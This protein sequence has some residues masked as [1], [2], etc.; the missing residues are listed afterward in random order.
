[1][2]TAIL[3]PQNLVK[4]CYAPCP[5]IDLTLRS[6]G[7]ER[8]QVMNAQGNFSFAG[9]G[10]SPS[11]TPTLATSGAGAA[12]PTGKYWAYR[13]VWVAKTKFPK[14]ENAVTGNGSPAPRTNP[15]PGSATSTGSLTANR[16]VTVGCSSDPAISHIWIYRTTYADS[17]VE[18][19]TFSDAGVLFWIGEVAND[20]MSATTT[21][22][23][24]SAGAGLEQIEND[25]FDAPQ[26][27]LC[28]FADPYFYGIGNND[29]VCNVSIGTDNVVM[30]VPARS[31][32]EQWF[33]GRDGQTIT[34]QD[35]S[36]GGYD[37]FGSFYFKVISG[38]T[39]ELYEDIALTTIALAGFTG[40]TQAT[41]RGNSHT[42]YRSKP[43]NPLSWGITDVIDDLLVPRLYAQS[44]GAGKATALAVLPSAS[45]LKIDLESPSSCVTFNLRVAGTSSFES[46]L[47]IVSRT[48][49]A[50]SHFGQFLATVAKGTNALWSFDPKTFSI[51]E[52]DGANQ[53]P[54]SESVF[55]SL[56]NVSQDAEHRKYIHGG[57][58]PR[59]ELNL[60]FFND[61]RATAT[62]ITH[63]IYYHH[64]TG[65]W[66][67]I[68]GFNII[69]S[70]P[71]R[72]PTT[73]E[74]HL[75]VGTTEGF[76]GEYGAKDQYQHWNDSTTM[77]V[78]A[79]T[80][81]RPTGQIGIS[82]ATAI[83]TANVGQWITKIGRLVGTLEPTRF[84][85]RISG[86]VSSTPPLYEVQTDLIL[87]KDFATV[88]NF[89]DISSDQTYSYEGFIG[90][91]EMTAG[92]FFNAK[93]P[94]STKKVEAV[95]STWIR[96]QTVITDPNPG[97]G[98]PWSSIPTIRFGSTY[99]RGEIEQRMLS[100]ENTAP[101]DS[102]SSTYQ[103]SNTLQVNATR[104]IGVE[105]THRYPTAA[106]LMN[107]ELHLSPDAP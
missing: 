53:I 6:N 5:A 67:I 9:L 51:I 35:I 29:F 72:N 66:G 55:D 64:P 57:Y 47:R 14:V 43:K 32:A 54:I 87:D 94:I 73:G 7:E 71:I 107:Y 52:C 101:A 40:T 63:A 45:L 61:V 102:V 74:I 99:V 50:G 88:A 92:R 34:F 68:D 36:V 25:N 76:L 106:Q 13:Y 19:A 3:N 33:D 78:T 58:H 24:D 59:L 8:V 83:T 31:P 82:R 27:T 86:I 98:Y 22:T 42:L 103:I 37:G 48:Y 26:F 60:F 17:A 95:W 38:T 20:T 10:D 39:A 44:V 18:A 23:D 70:A 65:Q 12:F 69:C 49:T 46:S 104:V 41:I 96:D 2:F 81:G 80:A 16:V 100:V 62:D 85:A 91:I 105:L 97:S 1:M 28:A 84:Y 93:V 11:V 89:P 21:F 77:I 79:E 15:S 4:D 30:L 56:R 90:L 75:F